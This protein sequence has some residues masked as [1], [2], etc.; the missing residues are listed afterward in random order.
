MPNDQD[1]LLEKE[2]RL[3]ALLQAY[4]STSE[5]FRKLSGTADPLLRSTSLKTVHDAAVAYFGAH[6]EQCALILRLRSNNAEEWFNDRAEK[7]MN[8]LEKV[9]RHYSE[10]NL[11]AVDLGLNEAEFR[12]ELTDFA[13]LQRVVKLHSPRIADELRNQFVKADLPIYGFETGESREIPQSPHES[14]WFFFGALMFL[15]A[16]GFGIWGFALGKLTYD[17]RSILYWVLPLASGFAAG[18]FA[19]SF[20]VKAR[21]L[22]PGALI[23]ATGGFGVWLL[24]FF[25]LFPNHN[26]SPDTP[27]APAKTEI[28]DIQSRLEKLENTL[29]KDPDLSIEEEN[30]IKRVVVAEPSAVRLVSGTSARS[31]FWPKGST[32]KIAFLDGTEAQQALVKSVVEEWLK[33]ANLK[34]SYVEVKDSEVRVS[35]KGDSNYSYMGSDALGV[36]ESKPTLVL[37]LLGAAASDD[38]RRSNI[39]HEFGHALGLMHE[40]QTPDAVRH[41]NLPVIS[42]SFSESPDY[43]MANFKVPN[44]LDPVYAKKTFDPNSVMMYQF[45]PDWFKVPLPNPL[46]SALSDGDKQ[47]IGQIYPR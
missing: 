5:A 18:G 19:G 44:D 26:F 42:N 34:F 31:K 7:A 41:T 36:I 3:V 28:L 6:D 23:V 39:L 24:T 21:G 14:R 47:L 46:P 20:S 4:R 25:F 45:P 16:V 37:G 38:E 11:S 22:V 9:K 12:P 1:I 17:Q 29:K 35:F 33:Y 40:F 32:L 27:I 30:A 8:A 10:V 13:N 15:F 2:S 43:W